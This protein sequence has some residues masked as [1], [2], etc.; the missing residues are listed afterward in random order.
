MLSGRLFPSPSLAGEYRCYGAE[1][2]CYCGCTFLFGEDLYLTTVFTNKT[3]GPVLGFRLVIVSGA[4][5]R[6]QE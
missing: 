1:T 2:E 6:W 5:S 3:L 4:G